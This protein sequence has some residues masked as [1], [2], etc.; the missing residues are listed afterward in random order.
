V[1]VFIKNFHYDQPYCVQ[2]SFLILEPDCCTIWRPHQW[3]RPDAI[4][5]NGYARSDPNPSLP[6]MLVT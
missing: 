4:G 5:Q 2:Q 1:S 3:H 6:E